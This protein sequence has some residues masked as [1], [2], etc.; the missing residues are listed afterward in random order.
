MRVYVLHKKYTD[1]DSSFF[2]DDDD[3]HPLMADYSYDEV[4]D[5]YKSEE[6]CK[7]EKE[8]LEINRKKERAKWEKCCACP[9]QRLTKRKYNNNPKIISE[10][11]E[12]YNLFYKGNEVS[13]SLQYPYNIPMDE[14]YYIEEINAID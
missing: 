10:Y 3:Y 1:E 6:K 8:K 7:E 13:C 2:D 11:C 4:V 9:I 5:Y 14:E 12:S